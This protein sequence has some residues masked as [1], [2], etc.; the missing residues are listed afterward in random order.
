MAP[1]VRIASGADADYLRCHWISSG[2]R[3]RYA[4]GISGDTKGSPSW[5]CRGHFGCD[6]ASH[7]AR[8]VE[9]SIKAFP[10]CP[11]YSPA[12]AIER[13][14]EGYRRGPEAEAERQAIQA[15]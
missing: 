6:D 7:G 1:M 11:N 13:I 10:V 8:I 14:R 4:G 5:Y 15:E 12:A 9:E 3:C 2:D